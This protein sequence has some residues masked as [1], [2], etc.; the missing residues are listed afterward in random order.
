MAAFA[1][2]LPL[3]IVQ[4]RVTLHGFLGTSKAAGQIAAGMLQ[5][6]Q[7]APHASF[8]PPTSSWTLSLRVLKLS[9]NAAVPAAA[10]QSVIVGEWSRCKGLPSRALCSTWFSEPS[11]QLLDVPCIRLS[12]T[13]HIQRR[14][15]DRRDAIYMA[16]FER[17]VFC[18]LHQA[19][20]WGSRCRGRRWR[21]TSRR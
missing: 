17:H 20:R 18:C 14:A 10:A 8:A 19:R 9:L 4:L 1:F 5:T 16:A 2:S 11:A 6:P 21:R 7:G 12:R 15:T 3:S 13:D